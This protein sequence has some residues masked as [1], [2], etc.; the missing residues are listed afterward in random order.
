MTYHAVALGLHLTQVVLLRAD[1]RPRAADA[2][3]PETKEGRRGTH[4]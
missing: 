2:D 4:S 1:D 3:V